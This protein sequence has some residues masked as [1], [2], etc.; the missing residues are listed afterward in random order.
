MTVTIALENYGLNPTNGFLPA[1]A[2]LTVLSDPYYKPWEDTVRILNHL[3]LAGKLRARIRSLPLL[4]V[5]RILGNVAEMQRAFLVLSM[6][7]HAYV[8]GKHEPV[9]DRLPEQLAVPFVKL[10]DTL[11]MRP[12]ACNASVVMWNW[13]LLDDTPVEGSG[14]VKYDMDISNLA[15][16]FTFSGSIDESWFYLITTAIEAVGGK[17]VSAIV[18]AIDACN[19][20]DISLVASNLESLFSTQ[21]E[22]N[23]LLRRMFDK[24]DPYVFYWKI[25]S[26]L[27]GWQNMAEAG[28]PLG[29]IYEGVDPPEDKDGRPVYRKY[30]GGS[31]AQTPIIQVLDIALGVEH[32]PTGMGPV[33]STA[34]P[35]L[36]PHQRHNSFL[37][38][39]RNYM[40][41]KHRQFLTDLAKV[42]KIR[43]FVIEN[44][45]PNAIA[46]GDKVEER[47]RLLNA[48]NQCVLSLKKFRDIHVQIATRYIVIPARKGP[49]V[50][51][52]Y[53][54]PINATESGKQQPEQVVGLRDGGGLARHVSANAIV[55][56]TGGTDL[57]AFLKQARDET[58]DTLLYHT[59]PTTTYTKNT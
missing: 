14:G 26:Y 44:C 19:E 25:R 16:Q 31:A 32:F 43:Q 54:T 40:P 23:H 52:G 57:M 38:D 6:L 39:M 30:A 27:A 47:Q 7:T 48:Y 34:S 55:R 29:L 12:V 51:Q 49:S 37:M 42:C 18:N 8:W 11:E 58:T 53:G 21:E 24:C 20:S 46:S 15:T 36:T 17:A 33:S 1:T 56:G 41:G 50:G 2:P 9:M 45:N 5:D 10:A 35:V 4:S 13:Q 3:L 28:L 59:G 22:I